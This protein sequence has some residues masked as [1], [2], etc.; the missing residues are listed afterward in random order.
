M[1]KVAL[2]KPPGTYADWNRRFIVNLS[3]ISA[4]LEKSGF[5]CKIFDAYFNGWSVAE[6]FD[7]VRQYS[8]DV[9]GIYYFLKTKITF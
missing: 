5:D 1:K 6:L 7:Q 2:I 8:P 4:Y 3:Y 9:F